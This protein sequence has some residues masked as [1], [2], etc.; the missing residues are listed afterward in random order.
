MGKKPTVFNY[1]LLT[2]SFQMV[3]RLE[4]ILLLAF[5]FHFDIPIKYL[6]SFSFEWLVISGGKGLRQGREGRLWKRQRRLG[7]TERGHDVITLHPAQRQ[8]Q[9]SPWRGR[10]C[11]CQQH[12]VTMT[13]SP[14]PSDLLNTRRVRIRV[15][16]P[17]KHSQQRVVPHHLLLNLIF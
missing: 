5:F 6:D 13:T 14:F 15:L 10:I 7:H 16:T 2:G 9:A 12:Q 8:L 17:D 11:G 4:S 1:Y 3:D